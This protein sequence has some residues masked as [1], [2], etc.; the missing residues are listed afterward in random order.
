VNETARD[1]LD[2]ETCTA[3]CLLARN[4]EASCS[5]RCNEKYH[6][7][8]AD[9][10]INYSPN[11]E[12][13]RVGDVVAIGLA[14]GGC[15]VGRVVA[16]DDRGIRLNKMSWISGYFNMGPEV[17][18]WANVVDILH[19]PEL[20]ED[21]FDTERLGLFQTTWHQTYRNTEFTRNLEQAIQDRRALDD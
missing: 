4:E 13:V 6:G 18:L 16:V 10:P 8:L 12:V 14:N 1:L 2:Q 5:C 7:I 21:Y 11:T 17:A 20:K 19:A 9:V 15:P 3:S